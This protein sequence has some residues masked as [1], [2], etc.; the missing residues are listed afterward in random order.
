MVW[1][2]DGAW[3]GSCGGPRQGPNRGQTG[4]PGGE[5]WEP[6]CDALLQHQAMLI[7]LR[8]I[9]LRGM[10]GDILNS[11]TLEWHIMH[12]AC[13]S[14]T[15]AIMGGMTVMFA[16]VPVPPMCTSPIPPVYTPPI[17]H[18]PIAHVPVQPSHTAC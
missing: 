13:Y 2:R 17:P 15:A 4:A 7:S 1:D 11:I 14:I 8:G 5:G 10:Q 3:L 18:A 6:P 9:S 16:K 12:A